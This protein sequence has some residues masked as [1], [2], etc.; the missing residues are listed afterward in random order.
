MDMQKMQVR[1][2]LER[3]VINYFLLGEITEDQSA[4]IC[5]FIDNTIGGSYFPEPGERQKGAIIPFP[6]SYTGQQNKNETWMEKLDRE[7]QEKKEQAEERAAREKLLIIYA[8][9]DKPLPEGVPDFRQVLQRD[10]LALICY[11]KLSSNEGVFYDALWAKSNNQNNR[12]DTEWSGA[13]REEDLSYVMP[14]DVGYSQ[15]EHE[16]AT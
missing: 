11:Q 16:K 5:N 15:Y 2:D 9:Y 3:M 8:P 13:T 6:T 12:R 1:A 14:R 10:G 4:D 7:E